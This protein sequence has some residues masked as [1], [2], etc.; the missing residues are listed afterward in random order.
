MRKTTRCGALFVLGAV[1]VLPAS[2]AFAQGAEDAAR[3]QSPQGLT[4]SAQV[5]CS[6]TKLR[7][8]NL[9]LNWAL[10]PVA[11]EA[12][13]VSTL[14]SAKQTLDTTVYA[15]GFEKGLYATLPVPT[16]G[17]V[18]TP[19]AAVVSPAPAAQPARETPRAFQIRLLEAQAVA[20]PGVRDPASGEFEAV[21]EDLEPGV[22]YTWRLTIET[23]SGKLVSAPITIQAPVCPADMVAP[24]KVPPKKPPLAKRL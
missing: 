21:V 2:A 24:K 20:Q 7:T 14:T 13:K 10:T 17:A 15:Q 6:E 9:R 4:L 5:F 1:L 18:K 8:A 16:G 3:S 19:V 23:P 22:N 11:R 12:V